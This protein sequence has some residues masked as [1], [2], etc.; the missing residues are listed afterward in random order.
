MRKIIKLLVLQAVEYLPASP[1]DYCFFLHI[2]T[3]LF[4]LLIMKSTFHS[5]SINLQNLKRAPV[6]SSTRA[7][8]RNLTGRRGVFGPLTAKPDI[9]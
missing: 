3:K 6:S 4:N 8:F 5:T 9:S 7:G 1:L 2:K